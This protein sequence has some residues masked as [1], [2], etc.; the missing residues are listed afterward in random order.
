MTMLLQTACNQS[1][2][3]TPVELAAA[4]LAAAID[5]AVIA[6]NKKAEDTGERLEQL[7]EL[8]ER[9]EKAADRAKNVIK[10]EKAYMNILGDYNKGNVIVQAFEERFNDLFKKT[11]KFFKD[12]DNNYDMKNMKDGPKKYNEQIKNYTALTMVLKAFIKF[13]MALDA[14]LAAKNK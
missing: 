9:A 4:E 1:P 2:N 5:A 8:E 12:E 13:S 14:E 7:T 10:D 11:S 3:K 6:C